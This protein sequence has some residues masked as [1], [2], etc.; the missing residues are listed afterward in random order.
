MYYVILKL[1]D[2]DQVKNGFEIMPF[3]SNTTRLTHVPPPTRI[4]NNTKASPLRITN[5]K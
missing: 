5:L 4:P 2:I 1:K 3:A